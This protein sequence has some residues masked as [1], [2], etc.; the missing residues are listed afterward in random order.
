MIQNRVLVEYESEIIRAQQPDY[1]CNYD[2]YGEETYAALAEEEAPVVPTFVSDSN[3]NLHRIEPAADA[4]RP[5]HHTVANPAP[6]SDPVA[7]P[8]GQPREPDGEDTFGTGLL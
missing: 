5:P 4:P 1:T 2:D 8:V 3:D 6:T 7:T